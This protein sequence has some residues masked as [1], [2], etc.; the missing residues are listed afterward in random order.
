MEMIVIRPGLLAT[1]QDSGRRGHRAS[2]VPLSG[3]ADPFALRVANLL[4][5]NA[6][7]AAGIEFTLSGPELEFSG[8]ALVA[9]CGAEFAGAPSWRPVPVRAGERFRL[10]ECLRGCRAILAVAGGI[11]VEPVLGSRSTCIRARIGGLEGRPLREGDRLA[12][13]SASVAPAERLES[14]FVSRSIL[15]PYSA[16]PAVRVVAGAQAEEFGQALYS[17]EFG[18]S[19]KSDRMGLRLSGPQV[20]RLRGGE[21][22]SCA[23]APGTVQVPPDGQPIVLLADAQTIGGYPQAAHVITVDLP[24]AA[25]LRPGD[26]LRFKEVALAEAQTLL[27]ARERDLLVLRQGLRTRYHDR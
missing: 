14:F 26:S 19:P 11:A 13:G 22:A 10:G 6:E 3:A 21:M 27:L 9:V 18:V 25:Q 8:D 1:V 16:H 5:G 12:L 24:L 23:V 4:V 7:D 17:G 20:V 15:P 2:G